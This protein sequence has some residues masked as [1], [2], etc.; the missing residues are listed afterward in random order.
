MSDFLLHDSATVLCLHTGQATPMQ[1]NKRV[2]VSGQP[3]VTRANIYNIKGCKL[4]T[5]S[6]GPDLTA[7]WTSAST[8]IKAGGVPV[9]LKNSQAK[10]APTGTTLNIITTQTRV[11][12]T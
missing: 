11:K 12:G 4:P 1:T 5:Q 7:A 8:R 10:C 9:L 6:G 2:K 3:I